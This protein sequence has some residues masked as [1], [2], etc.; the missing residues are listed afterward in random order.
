MSRKYFSW[1]A[2][3]NVDGTGAAIT[4]TL[5]FKPSRV[6]LF[7]VTGNCQLVWIDDMAA[8][9]GQKIVDSGTNL[10]DISYIASGGVTVNS[11]GFQIGTDADLNVSAETIHWIAYRN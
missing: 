7:N 9:K 10:T 2:S 5:D 11:V 3:G 8:G 6:E 1:G 4:I